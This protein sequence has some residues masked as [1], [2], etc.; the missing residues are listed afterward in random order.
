MLKLTVDLE[1]TLILVYPNFQANDTST[2]TKFNENSHTH[3]RNA[4]KSIKLE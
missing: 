4:F 2:E 3:T 1:I